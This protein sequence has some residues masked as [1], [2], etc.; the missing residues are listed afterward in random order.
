MEIDGARGFTRVSRVSAVFNA[1]DVETK[2][3]RKLTENIYGYYT[4]LP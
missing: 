4:F 2:I 3:I 1:H